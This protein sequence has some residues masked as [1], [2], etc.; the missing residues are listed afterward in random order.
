LF[1]L[2][3]FVFTDGNESKS[4]NKDDEVLLFIKFVGFVVNGVM[5]F[6]FMAVGELTLVMLEPDV[7]F[8]YGL[9]DFLFYQLTRD[10]FIII[11]SL[12]VGNFAFISGKSNHAILFSYITLNL[13]IY[14]PFIGKF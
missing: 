2:L 12:N 8:F 6:A 13:K 7:I 11:L 10:A 1:P 14:Y 5:L 3:D 4:F 9:I